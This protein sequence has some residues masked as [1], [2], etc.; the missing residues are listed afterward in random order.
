MWL[1]LLQWSCSLLPA[2]VEVVHQPRAAS[3]KAQPPSNLPLTT[4]QHLRH[5]WPFDYKNKSDSF[6]T[7]S[8]ELTIYSRIYSTLIWLIHLAPWVVPVLQPRRALW[9]CK[10]YFCHGERNRSSKFGGR[11]VFWIW[12]ICLQSVWHFW[13]C[14]LGPFCSL[15]WSVQHLLEWEVLPAPVLRL[16]PW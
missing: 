1:F 12:W 10:L 9:T 13:H 11:F 3:R 8:A 6:R 14:R 2:N 4:L 15:L 16:M 5:H 7:H